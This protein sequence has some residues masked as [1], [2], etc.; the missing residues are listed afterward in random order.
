VTRPLDGAVVLVTGASQGTGQGIAL[1]LGEQ[2]A[3]V[4]LSAR[5]G[6]AL[7]ATASQI[8]EMGGAAAALLE[9][10]RHFAERNAL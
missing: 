3:T 1:E 5:N 8:D 2:G 4:W 10:Q 7:E 6:D 9:R